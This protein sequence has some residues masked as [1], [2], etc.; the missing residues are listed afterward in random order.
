MNTLQPFGNASSLI[1]TLLGT[2]I[3]LRLVPSK[4]LLPILFNCPCWKVTLERFLQSEN[5]KSPID[6][7]LLGMTNSLIGRSLN[8][9]FSILSRPSYKTTFSSK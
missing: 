3:Y 7:T 8:A 4:H 6:L 9:A 5:A 2:I 1:L